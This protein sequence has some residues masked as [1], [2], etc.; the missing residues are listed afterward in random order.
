MVSR[1]L[2]ACVQAPGEAVPPPSAYATLLPFGAQSDADQA[3]AFQAVR[4][5]IHQEPQTTGRQVS[6][7][8][9]PPSVPEVQPDVSVT[10][11]PVPVTLPPVLA[12][13][14]PLARYRE[15]DSIKQA[16][17]SG[18]TVLIKGSYVEQVYLSN[19]LLS[20][21]QELPAEA[22]WKAEDLIADIQDYTRPTPQLLAISH[23]WLTEEHP[24]PEAWNLAGWAPLL[25]HFA[26]SCKV[27][28]ENLAIF[29]D[30]CS[31]HQ[32]P[33]EEEEEACFKRALQNIELWFAHQRSQVWLLTAVPEGLP[34]YKERGWCHFER[35]LSTMALPPESVLDLGG[36][37]PSWT[38]WAQVARECQAPR[39]P[40]TAP[41]QFENDLLQRSFQMEEDR[42]ICVPR[43]SEV[44]QEVMQN[45]TELWYCGIG[46]SDLEA[47]RLAQMLLQCNSLREL[48]LRGNVIADAGAYSLAD[49]FNQCPTLQALDLEGNIIGP[50]GIQELEGAW[51]E[52]GK[53]RDRL[54]LG[55]QQI[56]PNSLASKKAAAMRVVGTTEMGPTS[57]LS[58]AQITS[59]AAK[60]AA[61]E[62]RI[63]A[64]V[65]RLSGGLSSVA[66]SIG[67]RPE[68]LTS[69]QEQ[70][71][72]SSTHLRL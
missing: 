47:E 1:L 12:S 34:L 62:A 60:Q 42:A 32:Q 48:G 50:D 15:W 17:E 19:E 36:L 13:S 52:A 8:P 64:S 57:E 10:L 23:A 4:E 14:A 20:R 28:T 41:E 24:D 11:P 5:M 44:F 69:M 25:K 31:L 37:R 55:D 71:P 16:L 22:F 33:R 59:L 72:A 56:R 43:Y 29:L 46:W 54:Q 6:F 35:A 9:T 2:R 18:D 7:G 30:W 45:L 40:P 21:R 49:V 61:F 51:A 68:E 63:E 38:N 53:S 65:H 70:R 26:R 3:K 67:L 39:M 27:G 58:P 66:E